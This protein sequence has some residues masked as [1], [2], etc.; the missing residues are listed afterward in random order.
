MYIRKTFLLL[1]FSVPLAFGC[2]KD[3][4]TE[5]TIDFGPGEGVAYRDAYNRPM[6]GGDNTDWGSDGTWRSREKD[7]FSDLSL[8]L[9]AA[10]AGGVSNMSIFP[11]PVVLDGEGTFH[12]NAPSEGRGKLVWVS[13]TYQVLDSQNIQFPKGETQFRL[14]F[15]AATFPKDQKYRLYYVL[16]KTDGSLLL[17]GHGD[18]LI[19]KPL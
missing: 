4:D 3:N 8:N 12:F 1:A 14:S 5:A 13:K 9:D 2:K 15:P 6:G 7:L 17:K 16:S 18:L 11:N 10:Q 19:Y